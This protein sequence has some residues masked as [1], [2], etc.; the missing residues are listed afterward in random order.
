MSRFT[1]DGRYPP[2]HHRSEPDAAPRL[3]RLARLSLEVSNPHLNQAWPISLIAAHKFVLVAMADHACDICGLTW[4]GIRRLMRETGLYERTIQTALSALTA[5]GL[6]SI[7]SY[8]HGGRGRTTE[9][10]VLPGKV[11]GLSTAPCAKC[12]FNLK[13]GA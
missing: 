6:L 1:T 11:V 7:R 3:A 4:P 5:A 9:Y 8:P 2:R 13:K 10:L 12:V